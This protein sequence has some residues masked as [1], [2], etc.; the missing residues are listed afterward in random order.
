MMTLLAIARF[1]RLRETLG[2]IELATPIALMGLVV[3]VAILSFLAIPPPPVEE[4]R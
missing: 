4:S 1:L 3:L 2:A